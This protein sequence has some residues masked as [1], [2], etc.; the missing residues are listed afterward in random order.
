MGCAASKAVP[1][2][3]SSTESVPKPV[4]FE[5][6][7]EES[8]DNSKVKKPPPQLLQR[9]EEQSNL[10]AEE[11]KEKQK[12]AEERRLMILEEKCRIARESQ[13]VFNKNGENAQNGENKQ[14]GEATEKEKE[15]GAS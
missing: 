11:I 1:P 8:E 14:N 12:K 10:T 4:A 7:I 2:A 9:L 3:P 5:I 15:E 6:P 13:K